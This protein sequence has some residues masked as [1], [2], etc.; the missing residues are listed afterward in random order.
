MK[1]YILLAPATVDFGRFNNITSA[2]ETAE[3]MEATWHQFISES[4]NIAKRYDEEISFSDFEL[5]T[6]DDIAYQINNGE[7][8]FTERWAKAVSTKE[9]Y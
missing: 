2:F 9:D 3:D 4:I 8:C 7:D 5:L 6:P 1:T